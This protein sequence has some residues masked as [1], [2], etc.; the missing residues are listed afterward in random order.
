MSAHTYTRGLAAARHGQCWARHLE[1]SKAQQI[2]NSKPSAR[3]ASVQASSHRWIENFCTGT[4][5]DLTTF[6]FLAQQLLRTQLQ[7]AKQVV[8]LWSWEPTLHGSASKPDWTDSFPYPHKLS[9]Q[10]GNE[11]NLNS[12]AYISHPAAPIFRLRQLSLIRWRSKMHTPTLLAEE[13]LKTRL[14]LLPLE[15]RIK[16]IISRRLPALPY[17]SIISGAEAEY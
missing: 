7:I 14:F 3:L 5:P 11:N 12:N 4:G 8:V 6:V 17:L 1:P 13:K 9:V 2:A 15:T 16:S 10:G